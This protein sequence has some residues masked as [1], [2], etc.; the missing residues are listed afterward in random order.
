MKA[1]KVLDMSPAAEA[2]GVTAGSSVRQALY[3]C[4]SAVVV[5]H[6]PDDYTAL[7][8]AAWSIC[9]RYTPLVEPVS[10][11][12]CFLDLTGCEAAT[13]LSPSAAVENISREIEEA[14]GLKVSACLG[15]SKLIARAAY[16][17]PG[18][19]AQ[20]RGQRPDALAQARVQK[21]AAAGDASSSHGQEVCRLDILDADPGEFLGQMPVEDLK[22]LLRLPLGGQGRAHRDRPGGV[23]SDSA[24]SRVSGA[25]A[26]ID[27]L[28]HLGFKRI[29]EIGATPCDTLMRLV[30]PEAVYIHRLAQGLDSSKV[31]PGYPP[32]AITVRTSAAAVQGGLQGRPG[33]SD[34]EVQEFGE[35]GAQSDQVLREPSSLMRYGNSKCG[36][37]PPVCRELDPASLVRSCCAELARRLSSLRLGCSELTV[38]VERESLPA[39]YVS[40]KFAKKPIFEAED[41]FA[42]VWPLIAKEEAQQEYSGSMPVSAVSITATRLV[43]LR[44]AQPNL[45]GVSS[46]IP[47]HPIP[48]QSGSQSRVDP[49]APNHG[50]TVK[51][52]KSTSVTAGS[53]AAATEGPAR[54]PLVERAIL[55]IRL[56]YGAMTLHPASALI[57]RRRDKVRLMAGNM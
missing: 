11:F 49:V 10:D 30:G 38:S 1:G 25:D 31:I 43:P 18:A 13:G 56:R 40:S 3:C 53:P 28:I 37:P 16:R 29:K 46:G 20:T 2:R 9:Y 41:V 34:A 4:P 21:R 50:L 22:I 36:A 19:P 42:A 15:P 54:G 57:R 12:E 14:M 23:K 7:S 17:R 26:A 51:V 47:G 24:A 48:G 52:A 6:V 5:E 8:E 27:K 39:A 45:V 44:A 35:S 55:S 33:I 32:K